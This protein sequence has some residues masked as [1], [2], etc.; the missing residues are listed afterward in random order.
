KATDAPAAFKNGASPGTDAYATA[1][2]RLADDPRI[3]LVLPGAE[4]GRPA[5]EVR[6]I[7][8]SLGAHA[9]GMADNG[10][11]RIAFGSLA[12]SETSLAD[13]REH[14]ALV[15]NRRFVLVAPS[16]AEGAVVGLVGRLDPQDSPTFK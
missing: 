6:T 10:A 1:I 7:H 2:D 12:S 5:A 13:I 4:P 8:Q 9:V 15:R 16:G 14:S 11:P 3:D